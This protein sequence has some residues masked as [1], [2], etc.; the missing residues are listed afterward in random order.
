[1]DWTGDSATLG[2][3]HINGGLPLFLR[4]GCQVSV[5]SIVNKPLKFILKILNPCS[6]F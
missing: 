4:D 2:G 5:P 1:M 6:E 3:K